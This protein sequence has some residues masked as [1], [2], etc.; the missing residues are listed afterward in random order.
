MNITL[1]TITYNCYA[2]PIILLSYYQDN[3]FH[4]LTY[5]IATWQ[6]DAPLFYCDTPCSSSAQS[7]RDKLDKIANYVSIMLATVNE[8][9]DPDYTDYTLR[10]YITKHEED[11]V[12]ELLSNT[13]EALIQTIKAKGK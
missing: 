4:S 5:R 2:K 1:I 10:A 6:E 11:I 13:R 3:R 9:K 12:I 7:F 8:F